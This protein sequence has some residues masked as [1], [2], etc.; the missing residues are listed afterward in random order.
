MIAPTNLASCPTQAPYSNRGRA[1]AA[2]DLNNLAA[3][4]RATNR[5]MEVEPTMRKRVKI[6]FSFNARRLST[7]PFT[8][9][10]GRVH[11]PAS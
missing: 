6:L 1:D 3:L 2:I 8:N 7:L 9:V 11:R 4:L 5:L 10:S